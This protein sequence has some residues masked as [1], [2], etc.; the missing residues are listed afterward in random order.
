MRNNKTAF[1]V[2][3]HVLLSVFF[4]CTTKY[5]YYWVLSRTT[6]HCI[7]HRL[8]LIPWKPYTWASLWTISSLVIRCVVRL[9][10][11]IKVDRLCDQSF[12]I[13]LDALLVLNV[14]IPEGRSILA[15]TVLDTTNSDRKCS[16]SCGKERDSESKKTLLLRVFNSRQNNSTFC[17]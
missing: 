6:T 7:K 8:T 13:S 9:R 11:C 15:N 4:F 2:Y 10:S 3:L 5:W 1:N 14:T 16:L 12:R 17:G